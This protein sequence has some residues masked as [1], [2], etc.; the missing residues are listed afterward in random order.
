MLGKN[1]QNTETVRVLPDVD[2]LFVRPVQLPFANT[3]L[4]RD[5]PKGRWANQ[6]FIRDI[7]DKMP[8]GVAKSRIAFDVPVHRMRVEQ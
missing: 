1:C 5:F 2:E 8:S 4:N 3:Y 7:L 6:H